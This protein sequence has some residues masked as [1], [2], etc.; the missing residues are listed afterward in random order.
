M[1]TADS[2]G[3]ATIITDGGRPSREVAR[4]PAHILVSCLA[5]KHHSG[6]RR[7]AC[8][9]TRIAVAAG[10]TASCLW[11]WTATAGRAPSL[12]ASDEEVIFACSTG[13]KIV[14]VCASRDLSDQAGWLQYRFGPPGSPELVHPQEKSHP[15]AFVQAGT[16]TFSGGGGAFLRFLKSPYAYTVYTAIGRG[17][18]EKAG[19][20]VEQD[21]RPLANLACESE[22]QS[23]V[24][25]DL[26]RRAGLA[27]E[28]EAFQLP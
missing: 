16:W 13:S 26:F 11:G 14:S 6:H 20:A 12:C 17:W 24:G 10:V 27:D 1:A 8:A 28:P 15:R 2:R 23:E 3:A 19:V 9:V 4:R 7:A 25:P 5:V 22:V 18:G 21:G